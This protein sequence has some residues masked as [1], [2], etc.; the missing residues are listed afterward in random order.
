MLYLWKYERRV[1]FH[2]TF[3]L[4][5]LATWSAFPTLISTVESCSPRKSL[6]TSKETPPDHLT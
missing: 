3:A 2:L 1:K 5:V 4:A 6:N